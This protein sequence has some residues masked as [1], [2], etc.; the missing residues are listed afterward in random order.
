MWPQKASDEEQLRQ[1]IEE[2][3]DAME[4]KDLAGVLGPI[5]EQYQDKEGLGREAIR[6]FLFRQFRSRGGLSI[7]LS[8]IAV[9]IEGDKASAEF[10]A[11]VLEGAKGSAIGL[12]VDG[13]AL[14]FQV[15]FQKEDGEWKVISH[16]RE[17]AMQPTQ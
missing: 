3:S 8:P 9:Q 7:L 15:D 17:K 10:E 12:P 11:A 13:D 5:S 1:L 6:G 14:H 2:M 16:S 4:E